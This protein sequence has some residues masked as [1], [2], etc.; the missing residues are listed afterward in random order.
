MRGQKVL[1][2]LLL[3]IFIILGG[4]SSLEQ[5][6]ETDTSEPDDIAGQEEQ[7]ESIQ[8]V[9]F[10]AV[11]DILIHDRV[12]D[13][14]KVADGYDFYP[15]LERVERY[16]ADSTVTFANQ[17]T[18]IGG[19]EFGLSSYPAFNSPVEVGEVL[20]EVGVDIVSTANNHT[21]DRGED[22]IQ[23]ALQHWDELEM[24]YVGSYK[25]ETDKDTIR[26]IET[27][28]GISLGFLA[29]TY[30]T[31]GIPIPEGKDFLVNLIDKERITSEIE[32]IKEEVD[33]VIVSMHFGDEDVQMPNDE[34]EDLVRHIAD[35]G[36]DIVLGHH[37]HVLQP[38]EWIEGEDGNETFVIYSLGNFFSGQRELYQKIGGILTL[39]ITK[40][41]DESGSMIDVHSPQFMLTYNV[42]QNEANY[43]VLPWSEVNE[44]D[45]P[46]KAVIYDEMYEHMTQWMPE[47]EFI[48]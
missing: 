29:Y 16:L 42:D 44:A 8:E 21:L 10:S 38:T 46:D 37:P 17:E 41:K 23:S 13:D 2:S 34:Q 48:E 11:G 31:N 24:M 7:E 43:I 19:E 28:E 15:M 9:T 4:C 22:V 26:I 40:T 36:A 14:A 3:S 25:D 39:T 6:I 33:V 27:E 35:E 47:L 5:E 45:L 12:Y 30:G 18:M 32:E 1:V 20:K